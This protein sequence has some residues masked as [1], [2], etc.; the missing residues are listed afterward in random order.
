MPAKKQ[1]DGRYR[2]TVYLG[3]DIYGKK[4]YKD[5]Y[6]KTEKEC[7]DKEIEFKYKLLHNQ[8]EE[9]KHNNDLITFEDFYDN[10]LKNRDDILENTKTEYESVKKCHLKKL[11]KMDAKKIDKKVIKTF[12]S[13][14]KKEKGDKIVIRVSQKLNTFLKDMAISEDCP[15]TKDVLDEVKIPT[16]KKV[17]HYIIK[18]NEY[19]SFLK[20]LKKSFYNNEEYGFL[21]PLILICGGCGFRI[22]EALAINYVTDINLKENY[23]QISKEQTNIKGKGHVIVERTKTESGRRKAVIPKFIKKDLVELITFKLSQVEK[24]KKFDL[25][26]QFPTCIYIDKNNNEN[27]IT[28]ESLLITTNSFKMIPKNTAQ[29][30]WKKFRESLGYSDKIRIH[31]FRRFFA[32]LLLKEKIPN[33]VSI[34]QMGHAIIEDTEYYQDADIDIL[35]QY[36]GQISI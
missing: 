26:Y 8:I 1:K 6:G 17:K 25:E 13:E 32:R 5:I 22:G 15:I 16:R 23:I 18:E 24:I 31:D 3:K 11:L 12:Y 2:A 14:L 33:V 20:K 27:I 30:N 9:Y 35:N 7:N 4:K 29:R 19:K 34:A 36:I 28:S 10:W 21:Y